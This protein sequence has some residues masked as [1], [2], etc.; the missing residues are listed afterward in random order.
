MK[1]LTLIFFLLFCFT[2]SSSN[3]WAEYQSG[4]NPKEE[5]NCKYSLGSERI[6][7]HENGVTAP[8]VIFKEDSDGLDEI[9]KY[10]KDTTFNFKFAVNG[11]LIRTILSDS[12]QEEPLK[13]VFHEVVENN[14]HTIIA[15]NTDI[16]RSIFTNTIIFKNNNPINSVETINIFEIEDGVRNHFA[17][18]TQGRCERVIN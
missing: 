11:D 10:L 2:L 9:A 14:E 7:N 13:V 6:F 12:I 5:Y 8:L 4:Y 16:S 17:L 3:T 18:T 1:I 15:Y